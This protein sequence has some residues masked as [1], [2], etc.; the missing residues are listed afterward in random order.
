MG[1]IFAFGGAQKALRFCMGRTENHLPPVPVYVPKRRP[2]DP[3]P[4]LVFGSGQP[5]YQR[6]IPEICGI[7]CLKMVGDTIGVTS[8]LSLYQLTMMAAANGTFKVS[9]C[10]TIQ[11]AFHYPLAELAESLGM[12]CRVARTLGIGEITEALA[13]GMYAILSID[14]AKVDSSLRGGHLVL[15]YGYDQPTGSFLLHDCSSVMRPD[16][17]GVNISADTLARISNNKGLVAGR[18]VRG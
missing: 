17:C 4:W 13:Q 14:T 15:V 16:G 12:R 2:D 8:K 7:C 10:G 11:G 6:W 18:A 5:E 9:E 3:E 1:A